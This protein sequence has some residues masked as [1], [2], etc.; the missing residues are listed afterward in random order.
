[1]GKALIKT[2]CVIFGGMIEE[3]PTHMADDLKT[4]DSIICA[5]KGYIYALKNGIKPDLIIGD[6]DSAKEPEM[7][8]VKIIKLPSVK[9][10]TDLHFA[11]KEGIKYGFKDFLISGVTGGRIDHTLASFSTLNFLSER[12]CTCKIVDKDTMA[13]VVNAALEIKKPEFEC[14]ISVFPIGEK[15]VID[16]IGANYEV[17]KLEI[18]N[19]F[20]VGVSNEFCLDTV[21]I[22]V[23]KGSCL[24]LIVKKENE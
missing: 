21:Q 22:A 3:I 5:D 12:G 19:T 23:L 17:S 11:V 8:D 10:D 16:I 7:S 4:T 13:F 24:V 2:R 9:D 1:M 15:A 6:F 14:Y 20:P 18:T